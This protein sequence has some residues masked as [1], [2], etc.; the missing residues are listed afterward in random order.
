LSTPP[1]VANNTDTEINKALIA[2]AGLVDGIDESIRSA[3]AIADAAI[4]SRVVALES[5]LDILARSYKAGGAISYAGAND[6]HTVQPLALGV[7]YQGTAPGAVMRR[8]LVTVPQTTITNA[9]ANYPAAGAWAFVTVNYLG[10]LQLR[11]AAGALT[12]RPT[13]NLFQLT[14]GG[15]GYDDIDRFGYYYADG[16][17]VVGVVGKVSASSFVYIINSTETDEEGTCQARIFGGTVAGAPT[18]YIGLRELKWTTC[19]GRNTFSIRLQTSGVGTMTGAVL[20]GLP[21]PTG[22]GVGWPCAF[23]YCAGHNPG[24]GAIPHCRISQATQAIECYAFN[25]A[26]GAESQQG[27]ANYAAVNIELFGFYPIR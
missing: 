12:A 25:P 8:Y 26:T 23:G 24:A 10:V 27:V 7:W 1:R 6:T 22:A 13:D 9:F 3:F 20:Y 15:V 16:E 5:N 14:G 4:V 2:F 18:A 17:R 19:N 11:A 21:R